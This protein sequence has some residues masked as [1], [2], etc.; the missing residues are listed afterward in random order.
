MQN[1]TLALGSPEQVDKRLRE[2]CRPEFGGVPPGD[3]Y[4]AVGLFAAMKGFFQNG[5]DKAI[6]GFRS[7][8]EWKNNRADVL[9]VSHGYIYSYPN[10]HEFLVPLL[11]NPKDDLQRLGTPKAIKLAD[12]TLKAPEKLTSDFLRES[13]DMNGLDVEERVD[14]LLGKNSIWPKDIVIDSHATA[15]A[16]LLQLGQWEGYDVYTADPSKKFGEKKLS[17]FATLGALPSELAAFKRVDV[18]WFPKG[19][20]QLILFEVEHT[21]NMNDA[22]LRMLKLPWVNAKL[23]IIAPESARQRYQQKIEAEPIRSYQSKCRFRSYPELRLLYQKASR[24]RRAY[25]TFFE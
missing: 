21:R 23:F 8:N 17:E 11:S 5:S 12:L 1:Q 4:E 2:I 9:G 16:V 14:S 6:L 3:L 10:I 25:K 13:F 15:Q 24:F 22:F 20:E 19:P 7:Y 18:V